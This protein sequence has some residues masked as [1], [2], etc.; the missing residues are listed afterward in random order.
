[1][2]AELG[3]A[4][5]LLAALAV[6]IMGF[7]IQRGA[8]CLVAAVRQVVD[9]HGPARLLALLEAAAWVSGGLIV[10]RALGLSMA[11]PIDHALTWQ[12]L[13]GG[14]LLGIGAAVAGA[15][16]F[17][18]IGRLGSGEWAFAATPLGFFAGC[19]V[20]ARAGIVVSPGVPAAGSPLIAAP[21]WLA[22]PIIGLAIA[23]L[24]WRARTGGHRG[25]DG[26]W[27]PHDATIVIALAF[28]FL[29]CFAGPWAYTEALARIAMGKAAAAPQLLLL[30]ALIGGATLGA[31]RGG[32][33]M[34]RRP[35]AVTL[36]RCFAGGVLMALG[37]MLVPGSNDGLILVGLPNLQAYA[38]AALAAMVVTIAAALAIERRLFGRT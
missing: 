30:G 33:L 24:I 23:R 32:R 9:G 12:V 15:C 19:L 36:V 25:K 11:V 7:G 28:V 6:V 34:S 5:L 1:M 35:D 8:T 14:A 18:A 20:L 13:A 29:M 16:V 3:P 4:A 22:V 38:W 37:A 21:A 27:H 17:G 26:L 31:W 2:T 10:A